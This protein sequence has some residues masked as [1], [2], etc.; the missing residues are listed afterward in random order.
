MVNQDNL[1]QP[2]LYI[3]P[4]TD[5][6]F[7]RIFGDECV[8]AAFLNDLLKPKPKIHKVIFLNKE[9][10]AENE[11]NKG[12]VYDIRCEL[13][14]GSEIIIEMQNR[15]Q[16]YFRDRIVYYLSRSI[17]P[18][19]HKGRVDNPDKLNKEGKPIKESWN[20]KLKPVYGVFFLNF[21]LDGLK[22]CMVRTV[23]LKVDE[24]GEVF[25]NKVRAYTIELPLIKD[26]RPE[27]CKD[28]IE[29]WIYNIYNLENMTTALPFQTQQPAFARMGELANFA[30]MSFEQQESY[31][32]SL[33]TWRTVMAAE[34]F[35][36]NKGR[37]E[38]RVEGREEGRAEGRA[39]GLAKGRA[40]GREEGIQDSARKMIAA[41]VPKELVLSALG[42]TKEDL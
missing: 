42:L 3:N 26:K 27:D 19:G 5:Y 41:G 17:T 20:F 30:N 24:T 6:G 31:M 9:E 34:E 39:E 16:V 12:V 18:Q 38:G 36:F 40:E 22:P 14:D 13:E 25:N 8:T 21:N 7:K 10:Q 23:Q 33:D 1:H 29:Y 32:R 2:G 35:T 15:E 28:E 11:D 37:E 4:M